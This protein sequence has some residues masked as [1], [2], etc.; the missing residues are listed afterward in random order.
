M[1]ESRKSAHGNQAVVDAS[2]RWLHEFP[3]YWGLGGEGRPADWYRSDALKHGAIIASTMT[4][5]ELRALIAGGEGPQCEF[6]RQIDNLESLAGEI[7]AFAN[8]DGGSLL[9][10]VDD[11]G[12]V[13]GV[14]DAQTAFQTLTHVCRDRCVPPVSPVLDTVREGEQ[15]V[16]VLQVRPDLNAQKPYRTAGGRFYV[17]VGRDK[18]DAT[19]R[20]LI[21]IAQATGE[22]H[23]D[24][25]PVWGTSLDD[26]HL[27]ALEKFHELQFGLPL[28]AQI[29]ESRL[30]L[31]RLLTNLRLAH[32]VDG[33]WMLSIG[34]L[35]VFGVAPQQYLPQ[36]RVS[37]VA[38]AGVDEDA[39]ILDRREIR[40]RLPDIIDEARQFFDRNV[41]RP[42]REHGFRREDIALYD[43][44][45]LGEAVVNAVA[46]RDY[47]LSGSQV[48]LFVFQDRIE[49][50]SPGRLPNS[51][52][53]DNITYGVHAERNR[54]IATL[55]TQL[56]YMSAIGTGVPRLILRLSREVS[57]RLP[58]FALVGE[59]LRLTIW[60][61]VFPS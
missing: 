43:K 14:S 1:Q 4:P 48:R 7:V 8:A 22:L 40:G 33:R 55:L 19:G 25:S 27:P 59:E 26:L 29:E 57:G 6:K 18:R 5:D 36:S 30:P 39:D 15:D 54:L 47:S 61:R 2:M 20:E 58:E 56:G 35:L 9:V 17:R 51:V 38:F 46:H 16:L 28:A 10:G 34:G 24:E 23:Y 32:E 41:A 31:T 49:I 52:S 45:A 60:A 13:L 37:A 11:S 42:A 53:L 12:Q 3:Q 21:R 50:R 44:R